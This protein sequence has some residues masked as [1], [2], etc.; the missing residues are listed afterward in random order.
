MELFYYA[1]GS[2]DAYLIADLPD[3][4]TAAA[5][6]MAVGG[7]GAG[8]VTA[9]VLA[10]PRQRSTKQFRRPSTTDPRALGTRARA[11]GQRASSSACL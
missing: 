10:G 5:P 9:T 8:S 3:E 7:S 4:A 6:A 2:T 1:F 11:A